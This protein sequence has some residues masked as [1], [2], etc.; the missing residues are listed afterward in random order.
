[1]VKIPLSEYVKNLD[2]KA[3]GRREIA[4]SI[5]GT[6]L[7]DIFKSTSEKCLTIPSNQ[8]DML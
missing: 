6:K 5:S 7:I 1:M 2:S 8:I 3:I 4:P